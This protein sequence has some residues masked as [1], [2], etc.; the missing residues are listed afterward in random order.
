ML[1][2]HRLRLLREVA[3]RGTIAATARA[4]A[5]TPSAVSQQLSKLETEVG[6]PLLERSGRGVRLTEVGKVLVAHADVVLRALDRAEVAA[7][8]ARGDIG[9]TLR[10][11]AFASAGTELVAPAIR[12]L[13]R[14]A[15]RLRVELSELEDPDS[16]VGLRLGELDLIILQDFTN[17]PSRTPTGL[18]RHPLLDDPLVLAI[19]RSWEPPG[20]D[21][22]AELADRPWI[23]E[24]EANPS[25][26]A[27]RHVC[28]AAGFEPDIR[29]ETLSFQVMAALVARGLGV[30]LVPKLVVRRGRS[31]IRLI[32]MPGMQRTIYA[33]TR[34]EQVQRPAV[35]IALEAI[36]DAAA[37]I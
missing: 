32:E 18:T 12:T 35:R 29:Y 5:F 1:D 31:G 22:L 10:V 19:P 2:V 3:A 14:R 30:A 6:A 11:G 36:R 15:P 20:S 28:R 33:A 21:A 23:A 4:L 24:P 16:I 26:R 34:H 8:E 13:E 27:L 7:H 9:G 17:V 25:G 37:R